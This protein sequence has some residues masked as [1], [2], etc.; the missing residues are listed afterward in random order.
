L[1]VIHL[2]WHSSGALDIVEAPP[3]FGLDGF[4]LFGSEI[5]PSQRA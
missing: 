5:L 1:K 3:L 4:F 2:D